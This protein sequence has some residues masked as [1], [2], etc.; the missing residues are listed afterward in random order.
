[1]IRYRFMMEERAYGPW[2]ADWRQ[3]VQDARNAGMTSP[4]KGSAP[5]KVLDPGWIDE[6]DNLNIVRQ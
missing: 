5:I 4:P 3:A 2:R 1:M 6:A